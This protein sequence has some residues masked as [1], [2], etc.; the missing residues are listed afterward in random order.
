[1]HRGGRENGVMYWGQFGTFKLAE[2][3][4]KV[5]GLGLQLQM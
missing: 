5:V 2:I 1:M 4:R 3:D